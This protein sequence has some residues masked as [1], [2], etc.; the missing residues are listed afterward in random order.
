MHPHL[1]EA[2]RRQPAYRG[3]KAALPGPGESTGVSNFP[4][5]TCS[6]LVA[7]LARDLERRIWVVVAA[8]PP[9]AEAVE[10]DLSALL[11]E[12]AAAL[13]PQREALPFEAEEHHVEVSG[14]RVEALEALLA[15]RVRVLVTTARA[16]QERERIPDELADLRLGLAVGQVIRP[17]DLADR[18]ETMG[19][20]RTGLVEQVGEFAARGGIVDLHWE[21]FHRQFCF[22]LEPDRSRRGVTRSWSRAAAATAG[23]ARAMSAAA[24]STGSP[25]SSR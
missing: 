8:D 20:E 17:G 6:L 1:V 5:S 18:L 24:S 16:L 12:G 19:F 11:P 13:Y 10:S 14:Q 15:G 2:L 7:T 9:E 25:R 21:I 23:R 4:G 22:R 3:L